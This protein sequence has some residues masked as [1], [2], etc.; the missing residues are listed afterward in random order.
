MGDEVSGVTFS[1]AT[2]E[3]AADLSGGIRP[4]DL[5]EVLALGFEDVLTPLV[6]CVKLSDIAVTMRVDGEIAAMFGARPFSENTTLVPTRRGHVWL[7]T[8]N[9]VPKRRKAFVRWS[10]PAVRGLLRRYETLGCMVDA[11]Y[12]AA[13]RWADWAG[14]RVGKPIP[15]RPTGALFCPI[16][17]WRS[18]GSHP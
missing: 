9:V 7:M 15:L 2:L 5:A 11:R 1:P 4:A 13:L 14:F 18:H 6:A 8:S 3:D 17:M 16:W 12:D 10:K